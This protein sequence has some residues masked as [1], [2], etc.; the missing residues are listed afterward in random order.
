MWGQ[1]NAGYEN[2]VGCCVCGPRVQQLLIVTN[3]FESIFVARCQM[4]AADGGGGGG[5]GEK[6]KIVGV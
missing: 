2:Q 4:V 3:A 5:G 1:R 6:A